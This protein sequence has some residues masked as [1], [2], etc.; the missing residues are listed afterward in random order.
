MPVTLSPWRGCLGS[1][2]RLRSRKGGP[3]RLVR[4]YL[5]RRKGNERAPALLL[6][7]FEVSKDCVQIVIE[8]GG[9]RIAYAP[10]FIDNGVVHGFASKSSSGV[11]M[12]GALRPLPAQIDS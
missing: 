7:L 1:C 11:Q 10:N 6:L 5:A 3:G 2:F 4:L 8:A 12:I 9:M